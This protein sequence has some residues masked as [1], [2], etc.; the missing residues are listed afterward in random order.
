MSARK[1]TAWIKTHRIAGWVAVSLILIYAVSGFWIA[2]YLI[3][4]G[5]PDILEAQLG[6]K[7]SIQEISINPF[8]FEMDLRG[9]SI[10]DKNGGRFVGF[11]NLFFNFELSS[12]FRRAAV[13][14]EIRLLGLFVALEK[15]KDGRLN[16]GDLL[17]SSEKEPEPKEDSS[18]FPL[19]VHKV[20]IREGK[21]TFDDRS[22][23]SD[24]H[25]QLAPINLSVSDFHTY[26][27]SGSE[28]HFKA[29]FDSGGTLDWN[30]DIDVTKFSSNGR[31]TLSGFRPIVIWRY[32]QDAVNFELSEGVFDLEAQYT[33]R[34]EGDAF[35]VEIPSGKWVLKDLKIARKGEGNTLIDIPSATLDGIAFNLREQKLSVASVSSKQGSVHAWVR[36][37]KEMNFVDLFIPAAGS[38]AAKTPPPASTA[39]PGGSKKWSVTV[40]KIALNDYR[41]LFEDRSLGETLTLDFRPLNVTLENFSSDLVEKLPFTIQSAINQSGHLN[42][43][44]ALGLNPL[45]TVAKLDLKLNLADFQPYV[46]PV[47]QLEFEQG[48]AI[49]NGDVDF[50][51]LQ[52]SKPQLQFK[53]LAS[54]DDFVGQ[55]KLANEKLL[56][57]KTLKFDDVD[58]NLEPLRVS[59]N[60]VIAD[61]AFTRFIINADGTTN[62]SKV[63]GDDQ[64]K[65]SNS[66]KTLENES[67]R[68]ATDA[69]VQIETVTV[70]NLS[71]Q[72]ADHSL[73]PGFSTG[74]EN[75]DGA[76]Q[77][78]S[79]DK[80]S[81]AKIDLK[82]TADQTAP[83]H[84]IGQIQFF[85]PELYSDIG[86][87]FNNLNLSSLTPY[88]GKFAGYKIK[89]G[90]MSVDLRYKIEQKKLV[91][92]N[93]V[94]IKR[95]TL[96]EEVES[97][98]AVS[99]PLSLAIAL[100]QDTNG[101][102]NLDLPL[103]G[104]LDD[105]EFSLWGLIGDVLVNMITKVVTSPFAALGSLING[106]E[107]LDSVA[108]APGQTG[109]TDEEKE[110]LGKVVEALAQRPAL[111]IEVTGVATEQ[112]A[113][114]QFRKAILTA[115]K[116]ASAN[117]QT[118]DQEEPRTEAIA[119]LSDEEYRRHLLQAYYMQVTGM[120]YLTLN[121]PMIGQNLNS[122]EVLASARRKVYGTML[123]GDGALRELAQTRGRNI[124]E[125]L[126]SRGLSA[127]RIDLAEGNLE[128]LEPSDVDSN[129]PVRSKLAL[130]AD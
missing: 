47:T 83:V 106:D 45:S 99:L 12:L 50:K 107:N 52:G 42:V 80:K 90:K 69:R 36:P 29:N 112:D 13:F 67:N 6:R 103:K 109:I 19:W 24:F 4:K 76:I 92:E 41:F 46:T 38:Q 68:D 77:G 113:E 78:L 23:K 55:D 117:Q 86:L 25:S 10:L 51:L 79:T 58:F 64:S 5:L 104:S 97:P 84:I 26:L 31:V 108:F 53:G 59:I 96:G 74:M 123:S 124:R 129:E 98:D 63:F 128:F 88:S 40:R 111:N 125:Y 93:N 121:A 110:K 66:G 44:G 102:I 116:A 85:N 30:G 56:D 35:Q 126:V 119:A 54:I 32:L 65:A 120:K 95:L 11:E 94:V 37:D 14:E 122:E 61:R 105:P 60:E 15:F 73:K 62:Y 21:V 1:M 34:P 16:F 71:A 7:G 9:L 27:D 127:E 57:W 49:V 72:F 89:K 43:T 3:K 101:V 33:V 114:Q 118:S 28:V 115:K 20:E 39:S 91:A 130:T 8:L 18:L 70:K 81:R 2:P 100:L 87:D 22:R 82:G 17:A 75:L 48:H